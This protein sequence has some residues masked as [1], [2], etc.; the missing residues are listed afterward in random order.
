MGIWSRPKKTKKQKGQHL[1]YLQWMNKIS[2][3]L[4]SSHHTTNPVCAPSTATDSHLVIFN[5]RHIQP[6]GTNYSSVFNMLQCLQRTVLEKYSYLAWQKKTFENKGEGS[7]R[8]K[9]SS[10]QKQQKKAVWEVGQ[11]LAENCP[12]TSS[13][14]KW[15]CAA[16]WFSVQSQSMTVLK[17][18]Q[19]KHENHSSKWARPRIPVFLL[20]TWSWAD[21]MRDPFSA[22]SPIPPACS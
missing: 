9:S 7:L 6:E 18:P 14:S 13:L 15:H 19:P 2:H 22:F 8:W 4:F 3:N 11:A 21:G 5:T 20:G 12:D 10:S 16:N 17:K 1:S